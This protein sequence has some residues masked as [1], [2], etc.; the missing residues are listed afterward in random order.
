[1]N[2]EA[3]EFP[4]KIMLKPSLQAWNTLQHLITPKYIYLIA[5]DRIQLE[6]FQ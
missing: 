3:D 6:V 1:L 2:T 4:E 5:G